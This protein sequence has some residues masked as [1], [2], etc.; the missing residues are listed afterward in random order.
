MTIKTERLILRP[1]VESDAADVY[2]Y[3][4]K[5]AVNCFAGM[6]LRSLEEAVEEMKKRGGETEYYFAIVLKETG[7]VIGEID[8]YPEPGEPHEGDTAPKDTFSP[9]WMLN[10]AYT[11]KGYAYEA[12]YAFFEYLFKEKGARRIYAYTEDYNLPSQRLCERLG[13]RRE[14]LFLEFI[15]FVNN[16]DGTPRY[17]NTYQYAVLKKEWVEKT[18]GE[19]Q[20][21]G[22][23]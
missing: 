3:L 4:K 13:M 10:L 19:R 8:A 2:E 15:S 5:P 18:T 12:A 20:Y 11:G 17:E 6:K 14:G 9:C 22:V 16:P 7:K 21:A 23:Q 1:F